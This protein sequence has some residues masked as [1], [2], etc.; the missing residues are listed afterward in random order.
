MVCLAAAPSLIT[1]RKSLS[2]SQPKILSFSQPGH[3]SRRL[4]LAPLVCLDPMMMI[5]QNTYPKARV[6][7]VR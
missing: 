1:N 5:A 3:A 6:R 4:R 2:F 7:G